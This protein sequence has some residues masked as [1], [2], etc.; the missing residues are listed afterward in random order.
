M[1]TLNWKEKT[2]VTI[3]SLTVVESY[4]YTEGDPAIDFQFIYQADF[5]PAKGNLKITKDKKEVEILSYHYEV[6]SAKEKIAFC[7][8]SPA[9]GEG[10][11][12]LQIIVNGKVLKEASFNVTFT[13]GDDPTT[14]QTHTVTFNAGGGT[15][16]VDPMTA[17]TGSAITLPS[18]DGL[19]RQYYTFTAWETGGKQ[20]NQGDEF[21]VNAETV[22]T[23]VWTRNTITVTYEANHESVTPSTHTETVN[24]G[25]FFRL[26][27]NPFDN[28]PD[29]QIFY[30]WTT[31]A[32]TPTEDDILAPGSAFPVEET[33]LTFYAYWG[34]ESVTEYT[35]TFKGKGTQME[36]ITFNKY[37]EEIC[38]P[39]YTGEPGMVCKGWDTDAAAKTV[40]YEDGGI[41]PKTDLTGDIVLYPIL[42]DVRV[43]LTWEKNG[44][45]SVVDDEFYFP[46]QAAPGEFCFYAYMIQKET[47]DGK[48]WILES[49]TAKTVS[50]K[51]VPTRK[52]MMEGT[53]EI[54]YISVPAEATVIT[55][56]WEELT[57]LTVSTLTVYNPY[58]YYSNETII[59]FE[60]LYI[61]NSDPK[62]ENLKITKDGKEVEILSYYYEFYTAE[63][64]IGV[65]GLSAAEGAGNYLLQIVHKGKVVKEAAFTVENKGER[66]FTPTAGTPTQN[67]SGQWVIPVSFVFSNIDGPGYL[68]Y[69]V[70][71]N[72]TQE[73]LT[74]DTDYTT[75]ISDDYTNM[76]FTFTGNVPIRQGNKIRI[77]FT[78]YRSSPIQTKSVEVTIPSS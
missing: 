8:L 56:N 5:N 37:T 13:E 57:Q 67:T 61:A 78:H 6:F 34:T 76:D 14:P 32:A 25:G 47:G 18:A 4:E 16:T 51:T 26:S 70:F 12:Q 69:N 55:L 65:C 27:E 63:E 23:A 38:L 53:A 7:G 21:T 48:I 1:I 40:V 62:T 30:G 72:D 20:Y 64:K 39:L 15:G 59:S 54:W 75:T 35:V 45:T 24:A 11:Y 2:D 58:E 60:F 49:V 52:E 68:D 73:E 71:L 43:T 77:T 22:F 3:T 17:E 74:R 44:G 50:G 33:E 46:D 28:S 36:P 66:T 41:I 29:G 42:E 10:Q 31:V 9:A 19:S